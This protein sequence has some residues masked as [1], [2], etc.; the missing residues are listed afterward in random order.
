LP[1]ASSFYLVFVAFGF[2][3]P[4]HIAIATMAMVNLMIV[5]PSS[6]GYFGPFELACTL[7]LGEKGYGS[8]IGF[9]EHVVV[10]YALIIHVVVQWIPSTI[11]G[12]IF[13]W[14]EHISFKEIDGN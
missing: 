8:I 12:L 11:L 3:G 9:S 7:I 5:V 10:A 1:E 14:T 13:M 6:P 4:F 2:T